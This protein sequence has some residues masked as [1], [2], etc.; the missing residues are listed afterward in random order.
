MS[1][2]AIVSGTLH[3]APEIREA[4]TGVQYIL[5]SIREPRAGE[6]RWWTCFA[7]GALA[8]EFDRLK[9]GEPIA[10]SGEFDCKVYTPN[11]GEGPRLNWTIKADAVLTARPRPKL[12]RKAQ[13]RLA[14]EFVEA[15]I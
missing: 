11:D 7:F 12:D 8:A 13:P 1:A 15:Q 9:A 2:R 10:V 5:C 4:R 3:R 14:S 6:T